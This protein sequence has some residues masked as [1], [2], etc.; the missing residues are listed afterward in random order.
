MRISLPQ[1]TLA[2]GIGLVAAA[3]AAAPS[4]CG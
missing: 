1:R 2:L 3:A 4:R